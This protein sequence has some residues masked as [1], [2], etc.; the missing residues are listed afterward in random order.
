MENVKAAYIIARW[1]AFNPGEKINLK[2]KRAVI[3]VAYA[4]LERGFEENEAYSLLDALVNAVRNENDK[5][6]A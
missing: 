2:T 4:M 6:I 3:E 1:I 5:E